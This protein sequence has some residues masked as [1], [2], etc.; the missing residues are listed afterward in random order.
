[1]SN[2]IIW[3]DIPATDLDRAIAFY[4]HVTGEPVVKMEGGFDVAVIG[5][6]KP[7]EP[8]MASAD[9]Y[10]G[11]TPSVDGPTIYINP[12]GDIDATLARVREAGGEVLQK[13]QF[14]GD[15]VGWIAYFKDSEGNKVGLQLPPA[16]M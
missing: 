1:M 13:K 2:V 5:A 6:P 15:V 10:L 4:A 16:G 3:A 7:G 14:M 8:V 9:I 12:N 11:G